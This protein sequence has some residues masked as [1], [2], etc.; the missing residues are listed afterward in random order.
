MGE[1][2]VSDLP[3]PPA[4]RAWHDK[5][6]KSPNGSERRV[7]KS[8]QGPTALRDNIAEHLDNDQSDYLGARLAEE[9]GHDVRPEDVRPVAQGL[10][11]VSPPARLDHAGGGKGESKPRTN[12]RQDPAEEA[13]VCT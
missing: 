6:L 1:S 8:R 10:Q 5:D 7:C 9:A 2:F 3:S 13:M 4:D 11:V 12:V